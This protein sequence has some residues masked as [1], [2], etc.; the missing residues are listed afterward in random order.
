MILPPMELSDIPIS[1]VAISLL[2]LTT[3]LVALLHDAD[4][5]DEDSDVVRRKVLGLFLVGSGVVAAVISVL[6][7]VQAG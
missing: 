2:F 1:G 6:A 5:E 7:A 3:G 4:P